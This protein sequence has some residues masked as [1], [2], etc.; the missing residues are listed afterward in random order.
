M[1]NSAVAWEFMKE[2]SL[3]IAP[4][5]ARLR[6]RH[7][8]PRYVGFPCPIVALAAVVREKE[9]KKALQHFTAGGRA[10]ECG[11]PMA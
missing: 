6:F 3:V 2:T 8:V 7:P 4:L 5:T 1:L 10:A 9:S 11:R